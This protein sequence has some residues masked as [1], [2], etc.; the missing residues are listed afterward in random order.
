MFP[1][2]LIRS[3]IDWVRHN[4]QFKDSNPYSRCEDSIKVCQT[5]WQEQMGKADLYL[6]EPA[7]TCAYWAEFFHAEDPSADEKEWREGLVKRSSQYDSF[8]EWQEWFKQSYAKVYKEDNIW[9]GVLMTAWAHTH[10]YEVMYSEDAWEFRPAVSY[11]QSSE[12]WRLEPHMNTVAE[13]LQELWQEEVLA[14]GEMGFSLDSQSIP[15][16][17]KVECLGFD[18]KKHSVIWPP[19]A[20]KEKESF[21][22]GNLVA[23]IVLPPGDDWYRQ[24][25]NVIFHNDYVDVTAL[26]SRARYMFGSKRRLLE[27]SVDSA[28]DQAKIQASAEGWMVPE[29]EGAA[30]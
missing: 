17:G 12:M 24:L 29:L 16:L 22:L 10:Q 7:T 18:T 25:D 28:Y 27:L 30:V 3:G 1:A 11:L 4:E 14:Y 21:D 9:M 6:L 8:D 2:Y 13:I 26:V 20:G 23:D 19:R 15:Y 5:L